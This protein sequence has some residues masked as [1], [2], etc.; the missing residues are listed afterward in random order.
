MTGRMPS[1]EALKPAEGLYI[2]TA[3]LIATLAVVRVAS[4]DVWFLGVGNDGYYTDVS[5]L[6][7][8]YGRLT[9]PHETPIHARLLSNHGGSAILSDIG[10]LG[11]NARPGDLAI[12]YYSGHGG[13]TYDYGYDEVAVWPRNSSDETIGR[14]YSWVRDDQIA[15]V[16]GGVNQAVPVIAIFDSCYAGGMVGG[17]EDLNSMVNVF[18]MMSSRED[19]VSYGGSTYS[20]F[21]EQLISGLGYGMPADASRDGTVTFKEWFDYARDHVYGQT[22]QYFDAGNFGSLPLVPVPEPGTALLLAAGGYAVFRKRRRMLGRG[23]LMP[24]LV[25]R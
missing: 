14:S 6:Y 22:P 8:A 16:I 11:A 9:N 7:N 17:R 21:T 19:Q 12:F 18:V 3:F 20:R 23:G 10:W 5:G 15:D 1:R 24:D 4:A 25:A 13:T 2:G